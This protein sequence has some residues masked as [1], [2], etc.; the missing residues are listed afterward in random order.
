MKQSK[1]TR[2]DF[3][4]SSDLELDRGTPYFSPTD[5]KTASASVVTTPAVVGQLGEF[6]KD[7]LFPQPEFKDCGG[8][9]TGDCIGFVCSDNV[10]DDF[11]YCDFSGCIDATNNLPRGGHSLLK[12]G[13][14]VYAFSETSRG[15]SC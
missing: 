15:L 14:S 12:S 6:P 13:S 3:G 2:A 8:F 11:H 4:Y 5:K 7:C 1:F 10:R 9:T